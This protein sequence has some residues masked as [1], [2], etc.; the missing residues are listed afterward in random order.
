LG[1]M[2]SEAYPGSK[3]QFRGDIASTLTRE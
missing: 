1:L 3:K 2:V